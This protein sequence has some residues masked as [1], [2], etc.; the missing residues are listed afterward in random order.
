MKVTVGMQKRD[1]HI[2]FCLKQKADVAVHEDPYSLGAVIS[3][4][5]PHPSKPVDIQKHLSCARALV[6]RA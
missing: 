3:V 4:H 1:A 2:V 6:D 5:L